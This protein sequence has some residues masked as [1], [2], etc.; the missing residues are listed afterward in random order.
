MSSGRQ[1]D[2]EDIQRAVKSEGLPNTLDVF[3]G[4]MDWALCMIKRLVDEDLIRL[5]KGWTRGRLCEELE[6][7]IWGISE[8]DVDLFGPGTKEWAAIASSRYL[9]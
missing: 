2:L 4:K 8:T 5:R 9:C 1:I 3:R 7:F 6:E